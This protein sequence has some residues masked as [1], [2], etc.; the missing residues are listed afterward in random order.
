MFIDPFLRQRETSPKGFMGSH[1]H[2]EPIVAGGGGLASDR[3]GPLAG[4][5]VGRLS[6]RPRHACAVHMCVSV[7]E[8]LGQ[9]SG[10]RT[11]LRGP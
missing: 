3:S 2:P 9:D 10:T 5:V 8:Y 1:A 4:G 11:P 7:C 6:P